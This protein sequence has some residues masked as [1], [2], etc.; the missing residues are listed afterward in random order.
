MK[1]KLCLMLAMLLVAGMIIPSNVSAR[2]VSRNNYRNMIYAAVS[3]R[4]K[5]TAVQNKY[6][7]EKD[8]RVIEYKWT[9]AKKATGFENQFSRDPKFKN[10]TKTYIYKFSGSSKAHWAAF[11]CDCKKDDCEMVHGKYYVKIRAWYGNYPGRWSNVLV[12]AEK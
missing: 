5:A 7:S 2:T 6:V 9:P 11:E 1:K 12:F 3:P 8:R 4:P 10:K